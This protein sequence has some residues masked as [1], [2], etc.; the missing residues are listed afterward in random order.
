[1]TR[2]ISATVLAEIEAERAVPGICL[3]AEFTNASTDAQSF[4]RIATTSQD[5][6][7][8]LDDGRTE[9]FQ[10]SGEFLS[11][12]GVKEDVERNRSGVRLQMSGVEQSIVSTLMSHHF[13][14]HEIR[15]W[16]AFW[17]DA[18]GQPVDSAYQIFTG[19]QIG[20]YELR[21]DWGNEQ[22]EGSVVI[23]TTIESFA[24]VN[25][26]VAVTTNPTSHNR[27]LKR[28]GVE[29]G[30]KFFRMIPGLV[31]KEIFWGRNAPGGVMSPEGYRPGP[32]SEDTGRTGQR[33]G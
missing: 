10:G 26:R 8:T 12:G 27:Y 18:T 14:G 32:G 17:D 9:T 7:V 31:G 23:E 29:T 16:L 4:I 25:P 28:I 3:E 33:R 1:M 22:E 13:R 5:V 24:T 19:F 21:E 6:D 15:M 2:T 11:W 30:D 20:D